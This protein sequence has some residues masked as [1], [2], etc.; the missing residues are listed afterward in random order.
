LN[1]TTR[2][3]QLTKKNNKEGWKKYKASK[4]GIEGKEEGREQKKGPDMSSFSDERPSEGGLPKRNPVKAVGIDAEAA[5]RNREELQ[6]QV[7][8]SGINEMKRCEPTLF[9]CGRNVVPICGDQ[10]M[11]MKSQKGRCT[12]KSSANI[13]NLGYLNKRFIAPV[14]PTW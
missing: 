4:K 8:E 1:E 2:P 14:I 7:I 11:K 6:Q 9:F 12:L 3:L 5:R 10:F 13:Y